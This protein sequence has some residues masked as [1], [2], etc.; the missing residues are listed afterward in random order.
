MWRMHDRL[1]EYL[2]ERS[3]AAEIESFRLYGQK[4]PALGRPLH[5]D[6]NHDVELIYGARRLFVARQLNAKLLVEVRPM[7]DREA[8]VAMDIENR[9]RNDV[10]PYERGMSLKA[11]LRE[12]YFDSQSELS[13]V[14]GLSEARVSRLL[15]FAEIPAVVIEAFPNPLEIRETWGLSMANWLNEPDAKA[16]VLASARRLICKKPSVSAEQ[17]FRNLFEA[18]ANAA[19]NARNS[20]RDEIVRNARGH[21]LFR[22]SHRHKDVHIVLPLDSVSVGTLKNI[23]AALLNLLSDRESPGAGAHNGAT[24]GHGSLPASRSSA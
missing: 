18:A 24:A 20:S 17:V 21:P 12:K 11:L 7:T 3:C 6:I 4:I 23:S 10:S 1:T 16:R 19:R 2:T 15:R 13:R 14:L 22:I 8:I 5:D 9:H